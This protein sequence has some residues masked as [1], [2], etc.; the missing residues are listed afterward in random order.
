MGRRG[1]SDTKCENRLTRRGSDATDKWI[2]VNFS[3]FS[4]DEG[5]DAMSASDQLIYVGAKEQPSHAESS[6]AAPSSSTTLPVEFAGFVDLLRSTFSIAH[7]SEVCEECK[8]LNRRGACYCKA[9]MN[10]L[11]AYFASASPRAPFVI[12]RRRGHEES[13]SG[14]LDLIAVCVVLISLVLMTANIPVGG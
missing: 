9:C 14:A 3:H 1:Q 4:P 2:N 11:P 7:G 12:W 5:T 13:G 10:K 8:M 6:T